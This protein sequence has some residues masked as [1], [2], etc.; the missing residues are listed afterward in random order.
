MTET[1]QDRQFQLQALREQLTK[2]QNH[3]K[4]YADRHRSDRHYQVGD[5]VLLKL[6][7]YAQSSVVNRPFPKL[8]FKYFGPY[9]VLDRVGAAAYRL[10]LPVDS[11][12]HNVFHVSQLK[13][14]TANYSPVYSDIAKLITLDTATLHPEAILER[15]LVKKGNTAIPQVRVK[16]SHLPEDSATWEDLYVLQQCFPSTLACGQ[17]SSPAGGGVT[18]TSTSEEDRRKRRRLRLRLRVLRDEWTWAE[19]ASRY[20]NPSRVMG[21]TNLILA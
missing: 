13:P 18:R 21:K 6:Q 1:I 4:L 8:A 16:W 14:F 12:V 15:R 17:A 5:L 9:R 2:A 11:R 10:E 19:V 20:I 7:P 3:M